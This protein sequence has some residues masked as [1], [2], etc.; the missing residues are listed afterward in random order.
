MYNSVQNSAQVLLILGNPDLQ[1]LVHFMG[2]NGKHLIHNLV[3]A[4]SPV[5]LG[6]N[7]GYHQL[8]LSLLTTTMLKERI[9][10]FSTVD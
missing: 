2:T 6:L 4:A 3:R 10:V 5:V 1:K 9:N 8:W 7:A